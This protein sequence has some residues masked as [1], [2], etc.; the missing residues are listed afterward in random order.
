MAVLSPMSFL[1]IKSPP[2]LLNHHIIRH[3]KI[4]LHKLSIIGA[5]NLGQVAIICLVLFYNMRSK[6]CLF[7]F[8]HSVDM[9]TDVN[10]SISCRKNMFLLEN[11]N[12]NKFFLYE[13]DKLTAVLMSL[14]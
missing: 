6:G 3:Q 10:L 13:I 1:N 8:H 2:Q 12:K 7:L 5:V 9:R 14:E 11:F 4:C